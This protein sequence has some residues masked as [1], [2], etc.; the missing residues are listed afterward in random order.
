M[1]RPETNIEKEVEIKC[2]K[3]SQQTK[4]MNTDA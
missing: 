3:S 4:P 2:N 1:Y